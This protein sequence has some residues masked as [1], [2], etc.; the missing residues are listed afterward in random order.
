MLSNRSVQAIKAVADTNHLVSAHINHKGVSRKIYRS[1]LRGQITLFTS[2]FQLNEFQKVLAYPRI[3]NKFQLSDADT[4]EIIRT[5]K[6][7]AVTV[8][9]IKV[10]KVISED[11]D[12]DEILAV[13]LEAEVD[14]IISGD[15]H[16]LDLGDYKDI[17]IV[18][19]RKFS[20]SHRTLFDE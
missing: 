17:Q 4:G 1:F 5:F 11:P 8:Y 15:A 9:P 3:K 20:M 10:D 2:A 6:K 7:Y 14:Y 12:D 13:A 16:L 18:T 19:A